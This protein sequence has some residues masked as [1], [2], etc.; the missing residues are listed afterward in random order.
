MRK[1]QFMSASTFH[2]RASRDP[3]RR[4]AIKQA[5]VA[6]AKDRKPA[7]SVGLVMN[8]SSMLDLM[9]YDPVTNASL[10]MTRQ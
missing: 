3:E 2:V 10:I 1:R 8:R 4:V 7:N 9:V 6:A 5:I